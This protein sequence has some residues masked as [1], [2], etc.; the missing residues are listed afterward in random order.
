MDIMNFLHF[1]ALTTLHFYNIPNLYYRGNMS[2]FYY[3][4]DV[5]ICN[6]N[7]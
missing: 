6:M 1:K 5:H 2:T 3:V 7:D 4:S